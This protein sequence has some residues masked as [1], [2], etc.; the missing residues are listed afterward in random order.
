MAEPY[1][2]QAAAWPGA[3]PPRPPTAGFWP[4]FGATLIDGFMFSVPAYVLWLAFVPSLLTDD[5]FELCE[6]EFG[7]QEFCNPVT[8]SDFR[9][10]FAAMAIFWVATMVGAIVY[11]GWLDG[12]SGQ[13]LGRRATGIRVV[14]ADTL[15]PIGPGRAVGRH[16]LKILS[17]MPCYLGFLWMLWDDRGQAWHD[18]LVNTMVIEARSGAVPGHGYP[19]APSWAQPPQPGGA[20]PAPPAP[21]RPSWG[22]PPPPPPP[23]PPPTP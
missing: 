17:A 18:K 6:N 22:L 20:W 8:A 1:G 9:G 4:R 23:P 11:V 15:Q 21:S 10:I 3:R 13:T 16:L 19:A 2:W 7:Q 5:R 14:D 12:R